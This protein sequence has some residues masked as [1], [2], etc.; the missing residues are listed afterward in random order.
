[1]S[2]DHRAWVERLDGVEGGNPLAARVR[3]GLAEPQ[4]DAVVGG[5]TRYDQANR[6]NMQAGRVV[7]IGMSVGYGDQFVPVEGNNVFGQLFGNLKVIGN[8]PWETRIPKRRERLR[9][10]LLA[11]LRHHIRYRDEAGS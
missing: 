5:V 6:R 7:G 10:G 1:M 8:L 4:V 2:G 11:H 3:I 9:R